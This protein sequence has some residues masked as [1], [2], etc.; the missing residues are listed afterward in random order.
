MRDRR[1]FWAGIA[2]VLV[3]LAGMLL[4]GPAWPEAPWPMGPRMHGWRIGWPGGVG[5]EAPLPDAETLEVR[6]TEFGFVPTTLTVELGE[7][8]NIALRNEGNLLHDL[9]IDEFGF[10]VVAGPGETRT[11][12]FVPDRAGT[13]TF[14]C[15]VPGHAQAG[16]VGTLVVEG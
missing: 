14:Y 12:G 10:R 9:T 1:L 13:F 2:L 8:V 7:P 6:A 5:T 15:S 3:G 11:A 4:G 16:M